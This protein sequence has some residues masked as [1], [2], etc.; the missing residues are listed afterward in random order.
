VDLDTWVREYK[1]EREHSGK[2]CFG[3]TPCRRSWIRYT[4]RGRRCRTVLADGMRLTPPAYALRRNGALKS[5]V[6]TQ[7]ASRLHDNGLCQIPLS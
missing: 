5:G 2:Y 7:R 3:K 4:W 6:R 1:Q